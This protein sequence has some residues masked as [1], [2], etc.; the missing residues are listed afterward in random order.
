MSATMTTFFQVL[1][2]STL[3][4]PWQ[5][6]LDKL[7]ES[8]ST[9]LFS[10]SFIVDVLWWLLTCDT[11]MFTCV[12]SC[13]FLHASKTSLRQFSSLSLFMPSDQ[14]VRVC[15]YTNLK[16]VLCPHKVDSHVCHQGFPLP[17]SF[18]ATS[19]W[20]CS[21]ATVLFFFF[22]TVHF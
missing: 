13:V 16:P 19:Q 3:G 6:M 8:L 12:C 2:L 17:L 1:I 21:A 9:W 22:F 15:Q 7:V 5:K 20:G 4:R 14:H 18:S 10:A 11:K